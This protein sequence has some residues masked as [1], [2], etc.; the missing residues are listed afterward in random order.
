METIMTIKIDLEHIEDVCNFVDLDDL[1]NE[2]NLMDL[3]KWDG[4]DYPDTN[5]LLCVFE[6]FPNKYLIIEHEQ[7][8]EKGRV[9]NKFSFEN[10]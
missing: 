2:D 6:Q 1:C 7:S 8:K 3:L 5:D 9:N 4:E 10:K